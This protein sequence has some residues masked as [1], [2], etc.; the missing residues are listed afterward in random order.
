MCIMV[1]PP[2]RPTIMLVSC[3]IT[4]MYHI[5]YII[6]QCTPRKTINIMLSYAVVRAILTDIV[7]TVC[8]CPCTR[9]CKVNLYKFYYMHAICAR[10]FHNWC[11]CT[12]SFYSFG[13]FCF[14]VQSN[15]DR[16]RKKSHSLSLSLEV[17][18]TQMHNRS[19]CDVDPMQCIVVSCAPVVVYVVVVV[20]IA[21]LGSHWGLN[22]SDTNYKENGRLRTLSHVSR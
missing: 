10:P 2:N 17:S 4:I 5:I 21:C 7:H 19:L 8:Q 22:A 14:S 18:L 3:L 9:V 1:L 12:N 15:T 20:V 16:W 13:S 6:H 11:V